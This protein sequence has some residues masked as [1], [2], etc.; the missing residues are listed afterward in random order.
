M[1]RR[2]DNSKS[3]YETA[4]ELLVQRA[5]NDIS[6]S[7]EANPCPLKRGV[8]AGLEFHE[9]E[10]SA[11]LFA[12]VITDQSPFE[13]V[14][15]FHRSLRGAPESEEEPTRALLHLNE[16]DCGN[17]PLVPSLVD[18][19]RQYGREKLHMN[20]E[21][22]TMA[23]TSLDGQSLMMSRSCRQHDGHPPGR[24]CLRRIYCSD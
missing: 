24:V 22:R 11:G 3:L 8:D 12:Q 14:N 16:N 5:T 7:G 2:I 6:S 15:Q 17:Q 20:M 21:C 23:A 4:V 9:R 13:E 1:F 10:A 19:I 18:V